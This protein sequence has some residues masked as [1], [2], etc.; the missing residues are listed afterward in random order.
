MNQQIPGYI[1][2]ESLFSDDRICIF[3]GKKKDTEETVVLKF[4]KRDLPDLKDINSLK[5]EFSIIQNLKISGIIQPIEL[6]S[7]KNNIA[8]VFQGFWGPNL[9]S[10]LSSGPF[11]TLEFLKIAIQLTD[12]LTDI[13]ANHIIHKDIKPSNIIIHS[14]SQEVK[15]TDFSIATKLEKEMKSIQNPEQLEGTIF[16]ISPEQTG[17]MNRSIDYRTDIYSL[18][19]T[20]YEMITGKLPFE[21]NDPMEIIHAHIAKLPRSPQ[22]IVPNIPPIISQIILKCLNKSAEDR[23]QSAYG[24]KLDL[25]NCLDQLINTSEIQ[26]FLLAQKDVSSRFQI[27]QK[28]YG[29]DKEIQILLD[30]FQDMYENGETQFLSIAG[31]SGTGKSSLIQELYKPITE[32]R[33]YFIVG[34]YEQ[35]QNDSPFIGFI[36]AF[37]GLIKQLLSEAQHNLTVWKAQLLEAIGVNGQV[38]ID[39]IPDLEFIIGPQPPVPKLGLD[40][41]HNR[42]NIMLQ[43]FIQVFS[44]KEH[45][46]ILFLDN[47][48]WADTSSLQLIEFF[49]TKSQNL[50]LF[51]I[52]AY[53]TN[54]LTDSSPLTKMVEKL[55]AHVSPQI[56]KITLESLPVEIINQL[57]SDT[58]HC[59][60]SYTKS[61]S[62]LLYEKTQGN[63]FFLTQLLQSLYQTQQIKFDFSSGKWEWDLSKIQHT[64]ITNNVIELMVSTILRLPYKLQILL[65]NAA[66]LGNTFTPD[67]LSIISDI[68]EEEVLA[69][70]W[71][72]IFE[73][74][75]ILIGNDYKFLHNRLQ[76]ACYALIDDEE[77]KEVHLKIGRFLL[78]TL[79]KEKQNEYLFDIVNHFALGRDYISD[80]DE[81]I[82]VISLYIM[83][84]KKAKFS[85]AH[86]SALKYFSTAFAMIETI[87][88]DSIYDLYFSAGS[89][90]AESLFF[91]GNIEE[92]EALIN[93][94]LLKTKTKME[95]IKLLNIRSLAYIRLKEYSKAI[96]I[97]L[98]CLNLLGV[99]MKRQ[100][101]IFSIIIPLLKV[102]W[103]LKFQKISELINYPVSIDEKNKMATAIMDDLGAAVYFLGDD[104]LFAVLI[105]EGLIWVIKNG[106]TE[107][108]AFGYTGYG[109]ILGAVFQ[110]YKKA[111]QYNQL[112][113]A[114]CEKFNNIPLKAKVYHISASMIQ[115]WTQHY[116]H[117]IELFQKAYQFGLDS[118]DFDYSCYS[119]NDSS[120]CEFFIGEN[121]AAVFQA[122][123]EATEFFHK[124]SFLN[125]EINIRILQYLCSNLQGYI[126][127]DEQLLVPPQFEDQFEKDNSY[128]YTL[129]MLAKMILAYFN[130]DFKMAFQYLLKV[131]TYYGKI[132]SEILADNYI[133]FSGLIV[134]KL[135]RTASSH[136]EKRHLA[137]KMT[138]YLKKMK[139]WQD[140]CTQNFQHKYFLML[141]EWH[142]I[143]HHFSKASILFDKA[144]ESAIEN[145]FI[146]NAAIANEHAALFYIENNRT[147]L[148]TP[149]L[150]EAQYFYTKWGAYFKVTDIDK[151]YSNRILQSTNNPLLRTKTISVTHSQTSSEMLDTKSV[152]KAA[153]TISEEIQIKKLLDKL[154]HL[155]LENAGAQRGSLILKNDK[156][157]QFYIEAEGDVNT[158]KMAVSD[159]IAIEKTNK[160]CMSIVQY[161]IRTHQSIVIED[162]LTDFQFKSDPYILDQKPKSILCVSI[163]YQGN[164]IG[165]IYLE[166][167]LIS[168]TFTTNR[169]ELIKLLTS[170]AAIAIENAKLYQQVMDLNKNLERKVLLQTQ[171]LQKANQRLQGFNLELNKMNQDLIK[172]KEEAESANKFKSIFLAQ[173]THD[174]RTPLHVIIGILDILKKNPTINTDSYLLKSVSIALKSGEKQL[175]LVNDILDLSKIESGKTEIISEEFELTE[176]FSGLDEIMET[177]LH[178]KPI[179]FIFTNH[180]TDEIHLISDKRRIIQVLTNLL[181]NA[182]KFTQKG[183][184]ELEVY[185]ENNRL[186]CVVKDTG[187][188]L[189]KED[190][191]KIFEAYSM[192]D[193]E[194]QKNHTGTGL[195][196]AI[197]KGFITALGGEITVESEPERGS[198]FKLWIPLNKVDKSPKL[199]IDQANFNLEN[200]LYLLK[201]KKIL[202]CDDDEFNRTFADMILSGRTQYKLVENGWDAI[203]A[204]KNEDFDIIF[205][206]LQM[207]ELDGKE[208]FTRIRA[209]N[210]ITPIIALTAQAIKGTKEELLA[211]GFSGYLTKPFKEEDFLL[212]LFEQFQL[213]N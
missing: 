162:A 134:T 7:F 61:L 67:A 200:Q 154:L 175:T 104:L 101:S 173:M 153:Q 90:K 184:I 156:D 89:E 123:E 88:N 177:L 46:L 127:N 102:K 185:I 204:V 5:H 72:C 140:N 81:Q 128:A 76:E 60:L 199:L 195:G 178:E 77:R 58:L 3:L 42:L 91:I 63:P 141:A 131:E 71:Q 213:K 183:K 105:L 201:T 192:V 206:D 203:E 157:D 74:L 62:A 15:I 10:L 70:L 6:I 193:N 172:A 103:R 166:N 32:K 23:Y 146:Q 78:Q 54:E 21:S 34:T 138:S 149:Y 161:V 24:L 150:T 18:G 98:I 176:I 44:T 57:I 66:C 49:L 191:P 147:K 95:K 12:I 4:L 160:V 155:I 28:L 190:L 187:I 19:I 75:L 171:D 41:T 92:A 35:F 97:G 126:A 125:Q 107:Y 198:I 80:K 168:N 188:G 165:L 94:I 121:L 207:P 181:S 65:K 148:A 111:A 14:E 37:E 110:D 83:A 8:I 2:T 43:K 33:G 189:S 142:A 210:S 25:Q 64:E 202:L 96:D 56:H 169:Q 124:V 151:K 40:E 36:R 135:Y 69:G 52:G 180:V 114:L 167:N 53:R 196:L 120:W 205:M 113:I 100:N 55:E 86:A 139:L 51:I 130:Q 152:L 137:K 194:L 85:A 48:H 197:C 38:L 13:H 45:P 182:T 26:P 9:K 158:V 118:G 122:T 208:T 115:P 106:H 186:Y 39:I 164:L 108:S 143:H 47:L 170:Q 84:G 133:F 116:R 145:G 30:I 211:F 87:Y 93:S 59:D 179:K 1:L 29:R 212:F 68:S 117:S 22:K 136:S 79:S 82:N 50:Q 109:V 17:R 16:Y 132:A 129:M 112:A 119:L 99:R 174:L 209:F 20:F 11:S 31:Y 73:G 159:P 144:I 27:P 163:L